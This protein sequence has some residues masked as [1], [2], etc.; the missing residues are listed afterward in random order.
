MRSSFRRVPVSLAL[1]SL[2]LAMA[3]ILGLSLAGCGGS[4]TPVT[5]RPTLT[6]TA[7]NASRVYGATNPVF[8]ASAS[9]A[10]SGDTFT[11]TASTVATPSS[12]VGTYSIVPAATGTNL[13]N[14]NVVYV[15]GTLTVDKATLTVTPNNQSIV[16][17]SALPSFSA[18]ITGF[19]NGDTQT[20]V[21]GLPALTTTATSSSPA[22]SY[23][24][25][26]TL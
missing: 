21:I 6:V 13:A 20:V 5:T 18:T 2:A 3:G 25:T 24:I 10:L 26:S 17:G 23:P 16:A 7:A 12:P 22:G 4:S 8:T 9:G 11:L 19:V 1:V 15:N 14:Y